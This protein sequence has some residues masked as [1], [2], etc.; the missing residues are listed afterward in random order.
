M[1]KQLASA[2]DGKCFC[3][4]SSLDLPTPVHSTRVDLAD[5]LGSLHRPSTSALANFAGSG[6]GAAAAAADDQRRPR[7][8]AQIRADLTTIAKLK[9]KMFFTP[10]AF[11]KLAKQAMLAEG[12]AFERCVT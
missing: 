8:K 7:T 1:E 9:L 4:L 5:L 12:R 11:R 3:P 2:A 6:D 10:G